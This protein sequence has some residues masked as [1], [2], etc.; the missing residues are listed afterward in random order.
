M[1]SI[2]TESAYHLRNPGNGYGVGGRHPGTIAPGRVVDRVP[3][4]EAVVIGR[5]ST[6]SAALGLLSAGAGEPARRHRSVVRT[7]QAVVRFARGRGRR[8]RAAS[9]RGARVRVGTAT[10]G[11]ARTDAKLR[12]G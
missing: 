7:F 3:E 5:R 1:L 6:R 8:A 11:S 9:C 2:K 4:H 12:A 10:V